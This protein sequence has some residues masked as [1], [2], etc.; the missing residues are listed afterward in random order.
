MTFRSTQEFQEVMNRTFSLMRDDPEL[1]PRLRDADT[2]QRFEFPDVELV[3]N[4][5]AGDDT[6]PNLEWE[7]TDD[8][9]WEPQVRL[10]M[11]SETA[12]RYFQGKENM[13]KAIARRR[14]KAGGDV[15]AAM[16][17]IPM[18]KPIFAQYR[19]MIAAD[20]PHLEL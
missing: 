2:P 4:V 16:A 13:A 14:I 11:N 19:A 10:Q 6:E 12:N 18:T 3:V 7:W 15:A 1:G 17:I 8:V 5:R 20:Y 9:T